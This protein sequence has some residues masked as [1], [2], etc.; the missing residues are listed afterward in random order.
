M[1]EE[2][3]RSKG[4]VY[5]VI[6]FSDGS[7][8]IGTDVPGQAETSVVV[9]LPGNVSKE[10]VKTEQITETEYQAISENMS[11]DTLGIDENGVPQVKI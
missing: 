3:I 4:S 9:E 5:K 10:P 8:S 11:R 7:Q 6:T 1:N 2:H